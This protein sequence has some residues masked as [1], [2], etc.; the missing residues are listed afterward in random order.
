[1]F[2]EIVVRQIMD[3]RVGPGPISSAEP[4][5]VFKLEVILRT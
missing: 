1:M 2:R 5:D 4:T 3:Y